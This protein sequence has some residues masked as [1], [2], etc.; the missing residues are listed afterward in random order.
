MSCVKILSYRAP[1]DLIV[2]KKHML[3]GLGVEL[4]KVNEFYFVVFA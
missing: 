3:G 1:A 4:L 2:Y